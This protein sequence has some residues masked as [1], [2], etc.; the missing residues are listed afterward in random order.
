MFTCREQ[1]LDELGK[2]QARPLALVASGINVRQV[3]VT[4]QT[5]TTVHHHEELLIIGQLDGQGNTFPLQALEVTA[6][7][8]TLHLRWPTVTEAVFR[9]GELFNQTVKQRARCRQLTDHIR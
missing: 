6:R 2:S 4:A 9:Q 3:T 5:I 8:D 1:L 7:G